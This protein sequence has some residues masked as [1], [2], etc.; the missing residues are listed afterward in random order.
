[1]FEPREDPKQGGLAGAVDADKGDPVAWLDLEGHA[2][3]D[4]LSTE[5]MPEATG[6]GKSHIGESVRSVAQRQA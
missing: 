2:C 4:V 1:M 6:G 5:G 3:E